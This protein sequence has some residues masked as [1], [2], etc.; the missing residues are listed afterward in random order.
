MTRPLRNFI[1]HPSTSPSPYHIFF[2][3]GNPGLLEYYAGFLSQL[4]EALNAPSPTQSPDSSA[5]A[6]FPS[7]NVAGSA[8]AGFEARHGNDPKTEKRDTLYSITEQIDLSLARLRDYIQTSTTTS[9]SQKEKAKVILI[10][11]SFGTFV[12][13]EM[14]KQIFSNSADDDAFEIIGSIFLFPPIPDLAE[15]PQGKTLAVRSLQRTGYT[16]AYADYY[17][18]FYYSSA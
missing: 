1:T 8:F 7:F 10:G 16:C 11:H 3:P 2:L 13:A 17:Y 5:A 18:Y 15:S 14:M 4:H 12:I 9:S 6:S